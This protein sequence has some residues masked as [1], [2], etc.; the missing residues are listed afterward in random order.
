MASYYHKMEADELRLELERTQDELKK[1]A[2]F[3]LFF[4]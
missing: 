3:G 2:V 1:A 4:I